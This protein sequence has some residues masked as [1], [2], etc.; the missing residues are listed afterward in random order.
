MKRMILAL[1]VI[2]LIALTACTQ[3][4][5]STSTPEKSTG[6][7][8]STAPAKMSWE[9]EW[10]K[11]VAL[12]KKEG[13]VAL[14]STAGADVRQ[15]L[16]KGLKDKYGIELEFVAGKGEELAEKL[17]TERRAGLYL[18]DTYMA[19]ITT[20]TN[21]LKPAGL[22]EIADSFFILPEVRDQNAWLGGELP[23]VD[24][25][26]R[27]IGFRA[28]PHKFFNINTTLV[29]EGEIK[30]CF[31]LLAPKWKGKIVINHPL[32]AGTGQTGLAMIA[33][34][35]LSWDWVRDLAKQEPVII[36]DQ[37]LQVEWVARGK[38]PVGLGLKDDIAGEFVRAGTP[39]KRFSPSEGS[40]V[41][42]GAGSCSLIA[43]PAHPNAQKVFIN[44]LLSKEGQLVYSKANGTGSKRVDMPTDHL[45][46]D[47]FKEPGIR[48]LPEDEEFYAAKPQFEKVLE[49]IFKGIAE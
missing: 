25:E 28:S 47:E 37:R 9:Q 38:Y 12:A 40:Y 36:K 35:I 34:R 4:V 24:K 32:V 10:E 30:S 5:T 19:G 6:I 16:T 14:Y 39:L 48:Y 13:K 1:F 46:P 29:K 26:H 44:W 18:A 11:T 43:K 7:A 49:E 33:T 15:A 21:T 20:Q 22:L 27:I 3:Q 31:D 42:S 41:T 17:F 23:F 2:C 45:G 8:P